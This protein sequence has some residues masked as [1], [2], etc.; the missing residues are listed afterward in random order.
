MREE[1]LAIEAI[2]PTLDLILGRGY[3]APHSEWRGIGRILLSV[4]FNNILTK[5]SRESFIKRFQDYPFP[6]GWPRIQSPLHLF[7]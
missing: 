7:L 5:R 6:A 4:L 1:A 2:A 3:D